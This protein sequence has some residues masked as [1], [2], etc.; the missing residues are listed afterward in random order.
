MSS[1]EAVL[2]RPGQRGTRKMRK[3]TRSC[4]ECRRR[5]IRCTYPP[6]GPTCYSCTI[7]AAQCI[8]QG[9][10]SIERGRGDGETTTPSLPLPR[11]AQNCTAPE[12]E[13][14]EHDGIADDQDIVVTS[15]KEDDAPLVSVLVDAEFSSSTIPM[16]HKPTLS[17]GQ[18]VTTEALLPNTNYHHRPSHSLPSQFLSGR[19]LSICSTLRAALPTYDKILSALSSNGAWWSGYRKKAYA[20]SAIPYETI[21][22][23][24]QRTY[25]SNHPAK[26]GA[27]AIAF[28]RSSGKHTYLYSL[29]DQLVLSDFTYTATVEGMECLILL[30]KSYTDGGQP[31]RAWLV[32]RKGVAAVQL[33]GL[34]RGNKFSPTDIRLWSSIYHGD[35]FCSLLLGLPYGLNDRHYGILNGAYNPTLS[36]VSQFVFRCAVISGRIID[37]NLD[38]GSP[39]FAKAMEIDEELE[40]IASALPEDWWEIP[41]TLPQRSFDELDGLRETLLQQFYYFWV[42]L[43]LHLP[44]LIKNSANSPRFASRVRC[45]EA[46]RQVLKRYVLLRTKTTGGPCLF[47]CKTTDFACFTAAVIL[48]LGIHHGASAPGPTQG[49]G[50]LGLIAATDG[51]LQREEVEK[52]CKIASQ[53][54]KTL[55]MISFKQ[56]DGLDLDDAE[57]VIPYFGAVVRRRINPKHATS[58][59]P[60]ASS[61]DVHLSTPCTSGHDSMAASIAGDCSF[62]NINWQLFDYELEYSRVGM[63][64]TSFQDESSPWLDTAGLGLDPGWGAIADMDWDLRPDTDPFS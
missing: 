23:F 52:K 22:I 18:P 58:D 14:G 55:R 6:G 20:I 45:M 17:S 46:A 21:E 49:D 16:R 61:D 48:L 41:A 29:V 51:I 39:S 64:I 57:I 35:R 4:T 2:G 8:E 56:D 3:G 38:A 10:S 34:C 43:Y 37:R 28:A 11:P 42:Q 44:F 53:C 7:R 40:S 63:D 33:M 32:W 24:G 13:P 5:K 31:K 54:R 12:K 25:T 9:W 26:L 30:G 50:D 1:S 59:A 60:R 62:E 15:G 19:S 27:L 47:E 36:P